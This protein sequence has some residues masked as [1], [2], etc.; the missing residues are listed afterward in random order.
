MSDNERTIVD[1]G[2]GA[3]LQMIYAFLKEAENRGDASSWQGASE[4]FVRSA[5]IFGLAKLMIMEDNAH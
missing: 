2:D 3:A 5:K 1:C 4:A